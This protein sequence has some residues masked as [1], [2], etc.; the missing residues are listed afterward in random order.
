MASGDLGRYRFEKDGQAYVI[1]SN[2]NANGHVIADAIQFLPESKPDDVTERSTVTVDAKDAEAKKAM[3]DEL[4]KME[5]SRKKLEEAIDQQP[6]YLSLRPRPD[7]ADLA[8]HIRGDVHNLG[9][10]VPRGT[11]R[12]VSVRPRIERKTSRLIGSIWRNGLQLLKIPWWPVSSR[13]AFG[14]G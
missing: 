10:V 12:L 2:E 6:K 8:I 14:V 5:S 11:L 9:K 1:V 13:T 7:A 4:K 3:A